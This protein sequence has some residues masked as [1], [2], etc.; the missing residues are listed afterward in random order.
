MKRITIPLVLLALAASVAAAE[1]N[2]AAASKGAAVTET[3]G[4]G[5]EYLLLYH[6]PG[7]G[8]HKFSLFS[9]GL[10]AFANN[11]EDLGKKV[12][13]VGDKPT[14]YSKLTV[15]NTLGANGW[16]LVSV[17]SRVNS[18]RRHA[19]LATDEWVFRRVR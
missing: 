15:L 13:A 11:W 10:T 7:A 4:E 1:P 5:Y 19:D 2:P 3:E 9:S 18:S 14:G 17:V 12:G 8:A 6:T 16:E